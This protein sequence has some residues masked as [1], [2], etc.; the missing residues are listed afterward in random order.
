MCV[1]EIDRPL[2]AACRK[3][4]RRTKNHESR[5]EFTHLAQSITRVAVGPAR[6]VGLRAALP[7]VLRRGGGGRR[8]TARKDESAEGHG[9]GNFRREVVGRQQRLLHAEGQGRGQAR[10][11]RRSA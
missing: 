9:G 6:R 3:K 1:R 7:S 4:Y 2:R 11:P 10:R 8:G 5:E